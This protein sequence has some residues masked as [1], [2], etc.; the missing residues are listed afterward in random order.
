MQV[1][2]NPY[3]PARGVSDAL[4]DDAS[5]HV[6]LRLTKSVIRKAEDQ[7][8]LRLHMMRLS[9]GSIAMIF[10]SLILV[11]TMASQGLI[12]FL[13][14]VFASLAGSTLG[15]LALVHHSK[16]RVRKRIFEF[17]LVAGADCEVRSNKDQLTL[18]SPAGEFHWPNSVVKVHASGS[19]LL[20]CP[21][22]MMFV[23]VPKQS[24]FH[25]ES[26]KNFR[27]RVVARSAR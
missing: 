1:N 14:G 20:A 5:S 6:S 25:D 23:Y 15:Y 11:A 4:A 13:I 3:Q 10:A 22:A 9:I 8:L 19:G 7:Y 17:G 21:E 2:V 16:V 18:I 24:Q 26:Y 27:K 12:M